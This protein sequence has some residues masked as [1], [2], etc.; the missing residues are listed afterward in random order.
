VG[1]ELFHADGQR[2]TEGRIDGQTDITKLT[3][4]LRNFANA[5]K[6]DSDTGMLIRNLWNKV[7]NTPI[8]TFYKTKF[9]MGD[10]YRKQ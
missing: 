9:K 8:S 3:V 7:K 1:A 4:A 6:K 2:W 10:I 5:P